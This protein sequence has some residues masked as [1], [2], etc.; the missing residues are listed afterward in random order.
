VA[1]DRT[2]AWDDVQVDASNPLLAM[3]QEQDALFPG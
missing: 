1:R 2:L 3:R